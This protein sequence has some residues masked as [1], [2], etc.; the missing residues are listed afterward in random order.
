MDIMDLVKN[1]SGLKEQL[2]GLG[3]DESKIEGMANGVKEQLGGSDGFDLGDLL[4]SLD[5]DSFLGKMDIGALAEQA[6]ISPDVVENALSAI[7][8]K[9]AEF[10]GGSGALGGIG[11]IAKKLFGR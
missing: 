11:S 5:A 1:A 7:A 9:V 2:S 4:T 10:T 6:G 8:P 3:L